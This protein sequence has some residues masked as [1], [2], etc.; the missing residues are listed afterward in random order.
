MLE[1]GGQFQNL[2]GGVLR[3]AGEWIEDRNP[4]RPGEVVAR[5]P[6]SGEREVADAIDAA[7]DAFTG[8]RDTPPA[9]RAAVLEAAGGWLR[10]HGEEIAVLVSAEMGKTLAEARAEVARSADFFH[11]YGSLHRAE[12][13]ELLADARPGVE[14]EVRREPLGVVLAITPWNDPLLTPAR[15]LA[16]ALA[17]GNTT[18][19]KPASET[20]VSVLALA[21]AFEQTGAPGGILNTLTG[22]AARLVGPLLAD[23]RL[24]AVS[25]TG[26]TEVGLDLQ[27]ALAGRNVRLQTEMGGKNAAIVLADADLD[28][29]AQTICAAAFGQSGQRC[30]ATSRLIVERPVA[31]ALLERLVR[32][33]GEISVGPGDAPGSTMGPL[34]SERQMVSVLAD[35]ECALADGARLVFGGERVADGALADGWFVAPTI[36]TG[37]TREMRIWREEVFGPVLAVSAVD[38]LDEA[39]AAAN[40]SDYGLAAALFSSS[41][42]AAR[43]FAT[44]VEAG[45][46]AVNLPTSG[47][48]VHHPFGGWKLSGSAFKEQGTEALHFYTR[49]KT[50]AVRSV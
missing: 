14:V 9:A 21:L 18:V 39:I 6:A 38:S 24:A 22:P 2:I 32:L 31:A 41:L 25:F 10:E 17:A 26:S 16:P 15:K 12:R 36:L 1:L 42:A 40:D 4:A 28:L 34:V 27:R 13:G 33:A 30:T 8:W 49:V 50:V 29:A 19:I 47:W 3:S 37:V 5:V 7:A 20:P 43:R 46:V 35:I 23:A 45:Q 11:Y 44:A 48:D